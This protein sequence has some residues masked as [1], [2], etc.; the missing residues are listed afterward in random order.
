MSLN[1]NNE[2]GRNEIMKKMRIKWSMKYNNVENNKSENNQW[3]WK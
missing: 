1:D 2:N 3:K